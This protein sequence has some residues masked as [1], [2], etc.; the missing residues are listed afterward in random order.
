MDSSPLSSRQNYI[1]D[2]I[3]S[4][5]PCSQGSYGLLSLEQQVELSWIEFSYLSSSLGSDGLL[6]LV[7]QIELSWIELKVPMPKHENFSLAFFALSEPICV[8]D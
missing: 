3:F 7:Q 6:S 8:G 4:Y 1:I 5:L 2:I